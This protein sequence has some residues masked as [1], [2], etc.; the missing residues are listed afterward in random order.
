M[1]NKKKTETE[2][3]DRSVLSAD[4]KEYSE[5]RR[6]AEAFLSSLHGGCSALSWETADGQHLWG[7]NLDFNRLAEGTRVTFL[8]RKTVFTLMGRALR[9]HSGRTPER[10]LSTGRWGSAPCC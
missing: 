10:K 1:T 2:R 5:D 4:G 8:P 9:T 3:A 7:R 6:A